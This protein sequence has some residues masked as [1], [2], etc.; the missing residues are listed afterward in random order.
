MEIGSG[1]G[2]GSLVHDLGLLEWW[3]VDQGGLQNGASGVGLDV[4]DG[5]TNAVQFI[6]VVAFDQGTHGFGVD[7]WSLIGPPVVA[8][9][10]FKRLVLGLQRGHRVL[11]HGLLVK[12]IWQL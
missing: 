7:L 4:V 5:Q 3:L 10:G 12:W 6:L 11:L 9:G 8:G 1:Q 2:L